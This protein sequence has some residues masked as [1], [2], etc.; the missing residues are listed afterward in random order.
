MK[1]LTLNSHSWQEENQD[2]KIKDLVQ[3]I[4]E[5]SYDVI[6]LQEVSQSVEEKIVYGNVKNNNY[7]LLLLNE[8]KKQGIEEYSFVWGFSHNYTHM[9]KSFEEGLAILTKHPVIDEHSFYIS[10][11]RDINN[12]KARNIIGATIEYKGK[13]FSFYSCHMG[14]WYDE[15]ES[16]KDQ[17]KNLLQNINMDNTVFLMGDF[18]NDA[19]IKG[20]GYEYLISHG[21]FD[22]YNL[23]ECKDDGVTVKGKIAG[24][25][26]NQQKKRID[27]ILTN[28]PFP[29]VYSNVIFNGKNKSI[30]SD[31]FGVEIE[32]NI[33]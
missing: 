16:F 1:L 19:F 30:I 17:V 4:K 6:A 7:A 12:W 13:Q 8:L 22:T 25:E 27:L 18:N 3:T 32:I 26:K 14:W 23:A 24:W 33:N 11:I 9:N 28:L 10:G 5:N 2:E 20:E 29:V 21:L 31:H 15:E